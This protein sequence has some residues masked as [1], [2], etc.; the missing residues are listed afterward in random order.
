MELNQLVAAWRA[1]LSL[2]LLHF[3][4]GL[5]IGLAVGINITSAIFSRI[6]GEVLVLLTGIKHGRYSGIHST[7]HG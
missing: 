4:D 5:R 3:L 2:V 7:L 1:L 6:I